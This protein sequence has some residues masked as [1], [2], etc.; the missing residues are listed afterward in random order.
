[1]EFNGRIA[2]IAADHSPANAGSWSVGVPFCTCER[3]A[4]CIM[5]GTR[6]GLPGLRR[7]RRVATGPMTTTPT[8]APDPAAV[9]AA[10]SSRDN[11]VGGGGGGPAAAA[12]RLVPDRPMSGTAAV[13]AALDDA[14]AELLAE[15]DGA[16]TV[17]AYGAAW[18]HF[19]AWCERHD[20]C[21]LPAD[22]QTVARYIADA[23]DRR[24]PAPLSA[25]TLGVYRAAIGRRHRDAGLPDPTRDTRITQALKSLRKRRTRRGETPDRAPAAE[26][27]QL[28]TMVDVAHTSAST[29]RRRVAA[30][31][32][33]AV[34]LLAWATADRRS[35]LAALRGDD[36]RMIRRS[37]GGRLLRIRL[38]GSKTHQTEPEDQYVARGDTDAL[39]CP[40]CALLRWYVVLDA[41]DT[42]A[43]DERGR[44]QRAGGPET[45]IDE[46]LVTDAV[47]IAVQ[48]AVRIDAAR[49][50]PH[51]HRCDGAWPTPA[52]PELPV[53]RSLSRADGGLPRST[54]PLDGGSIAR[55]IATRATKADI[56]TP[57]RGHSLRAGRTTYL[58]GLGI[59][60]EDVMAVTRHRRVE[61]VLLYDRGREERSGD[62]AHG[63]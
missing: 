51:T 48:R 37:G 3:S 36:L 22:T 33:I 54:G 7:S 60:V 57:L 49:Y 42:A 19:T 1:M 15:A 39:Y 2:D 10:D 43:D 13:T 46:V 31:R 41:H 50:D 47:S 16:G 5:L 34:L 30:R 12:L 4:G 23:A 28:R 45:G 55:I 59:P 26:L 11:S 8:P 35:E 62:V 38:R 58:R 6:S 17:H 63:L 40:W 61:T 52:R 9:G 56:T 27:D 20:F 24:G 53:F 44:Q 21:P 18:R 14:V 32:D 29:W 25:A